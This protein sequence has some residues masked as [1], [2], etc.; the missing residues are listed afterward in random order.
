MRTK[1][2][3]LAKPMAGDQYMRPINRISY[4]QMVT[5][6]GWVRWNEVFKGRRRTFWSTP[7]SFRRWA[8]NAEYLGGTNE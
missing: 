2:E 8:A 4:V 3:A 6:Q 5:P 1:A 7:K